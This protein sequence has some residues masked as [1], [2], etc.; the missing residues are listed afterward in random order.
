MSAAIE[1]ADASALISGA[2]RFLARD[3]VSFVMAAA[4]VVSW[5]AVVL[6][7]VV[8]AVMRAD[9]LVVVVRVDSGGVLGELWRTG[10]GVGL[11]VG[12]RGWTYLESSDRL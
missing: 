1:T 3:L 11:G 7:S 9:W 12:R 4:A 2:V 5:E 10:D 8:R 6:R